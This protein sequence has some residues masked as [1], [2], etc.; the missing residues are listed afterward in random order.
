M[1]LHRADG[2]TDELWVG[3]MEEPARPRRIEIATYQYADGPAL[4]VRSRAWH[5]ASRFA[6]SGDGL[7]LYWDEGS[8][9][10][11]SR[12]DLE[13]LEAARAA[14]SNEEIWDREDDRDCENDEGVVSLYSALACATA[15]VMGRYQHRQPAM[16]AVRRVIA[17][18][19]PERVP[20]HRLMGFN[21]DP[22]TT[23]ADVERLFDLSAESLA[24]SIR[25]SVHARHVPGAGMPRIT[26]SRS[27]LSDRPIRSV[28]DRPGILPRALTRSILLDYA[29]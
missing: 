3:T 28:P 12:I 13:I 20:D 1:E 17:A 10:P 9:A 16:Q 24:S 11:H 15:D 21:N 14:L 5:L 19:W 26:R 29:G 27:T 4:I 23:L 7:R 18:E 22:R 6:V 2:A 8:E 25:W